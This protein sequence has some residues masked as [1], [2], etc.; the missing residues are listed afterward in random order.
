MKESNLTDQIKAMKEEDPKAKEERR[1][2]AEEEYEKERKRYLDNFEDTDNT[3]T[4]EQ[5]LDDKKEKLFKFIEGIKE[6]LTEEE[7]TRIV[8]LEKWSIEQ[9]KPRKKREKP[10]VVVQG[11]KRQYTREERPEIPQE[12][13][14]LGEKFNEDLKRWVKAREKRRE[15]PSP[16]KK[17][18]KKVARYNWKL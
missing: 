2:R 18:K 12:E 3:H 7:K 16:Q 1:H 9:N 13:I 15:K 11:E 4:P 10:W 14:R 8:D 17:K 5:K 6:K